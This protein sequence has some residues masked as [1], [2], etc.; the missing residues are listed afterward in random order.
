VVRIDG[1][2]VVL[3]RTSVTRLS[4]AVAL[5]DSYTSVVRRNGI[6]VVLS[7]RPVGRIR[8][9]LRELSLEGRLNPSGYFLFLNIPDGIYTLHVEAEHYLNEEVPLSLPTSPPESPLVTIFLQ[10]RPSYP[11]PAGA[12]LI[13]GLVHDLTGNPVAGAH[14]EIVGKNIT[15]RSAENGEFVLYFNSLK[16]QDIILVN[17]KPLVKGNGDQTITVRAEHADYGT[18]TQT[19]EVEEG[20]TA[21]VSFALISNFT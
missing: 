18:A 10:P 7:E 17:G 14:V 11:F 13:R 19:I 16:E 20:T 15:N 12:T 2:E 3:D 4:L 6:E 8:V 1:N 21:F 9:L 5:V